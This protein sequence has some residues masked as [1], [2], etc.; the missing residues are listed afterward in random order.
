[1]LIHLLTLMPMA[2]CSMSNII[3]VYRSSRDPRLIR[4][5]VICT[6]NKQLNFCNHFKRGA[7][8]PCLLQLCC[9]QWNFTLTFHHHEGEWIMIELS[10]LSEVNLY[11]SL[12]RY[13]PYRFFPSFITLHEYAAFLRH[14]TQNT[15][16]HLLIMS[17]QLSNS[18]EVLRLKMPSCSQL[19]Y[20][21]F[22]HT[23][24]TVSTWACF[25]NDIISI[26]CD[27]A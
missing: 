3:L 27:W 23:A 7:L 19:I 2:S 17:K 13:R 25:G 10:F 22:W 1:M 15:K 26:H 24:Q 21:Y 12:L 6:F 5:Y 11:Y 14:K 18:G 9:W 16:L 8:V 20:K 4:K